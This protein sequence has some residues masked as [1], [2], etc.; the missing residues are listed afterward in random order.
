MKKVYRGENGEKKTEEIMKCDKFINRFLLRAN[1]FVEYAC[2]QY[3]AYNRAISGIPDSNYISDFQYFVFFKST[4]SLYSI[5]KLLDLGHIEDVFILLR[6]M[7]EGYL[8][9]RFIDEEY[10]DDL[11]RDFIFVPQLIA[12][13]KIIFQD[14][15][16]KDRE[17]KELIEY[18][19]R[20]PSQMK[21]GK[22]KNY[23]SDFYAYLCN[24]AHC[25][26]SILPCYL[27]DN[28]MFTLY[29]KTN[30]YLA[31]ILVLFV[32]VKIFESIV[33]VEGEDFINKRE[34]SECYNLVIEATI[35]LYNELDKFSKYECKEVNPE[36]N[37]HMKNMFKEMKKSLKDEIG[38]VKK[39]FL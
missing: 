26:F 21:L 8:A 5:R 9:S 7:F 36:L 23:F 2:F 35:Y 22:D 15:V 29:G 17:T 34:E 6:T 25:N 38:S 33:T 31:R 13:R 12:R 39:D 4:K 10:N 1:K 19:Q 16:A 37:K 3:G 28:N 32:Y 27:D 20:N 24:Y 30:E 11:L 18:I 14:N